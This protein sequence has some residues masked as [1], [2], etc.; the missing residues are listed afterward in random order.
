VGS[1]YGDK[2]AESLDYEGMYTIEVNEDS[3]V[4]IVYSAILANL[5]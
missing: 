3:A 4:R 1:G 2:Y 5:A